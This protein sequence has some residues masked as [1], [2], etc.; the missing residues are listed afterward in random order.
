MTFDTNEYRIDPGGDGEHAFDWKD[1]PHRLIYDLCGEVERL[2]AIEIAA[3]SL[4][5]VAA[6]NVH[7]FAKHGH[8]SAA[9]QAAADQCHAA[10]SELKAALAAAEAAE[11]KA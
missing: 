4:M 1:K 3:R 7:T 11:D 9:F 5:K 6:D 2:Q 10:Y 8:E